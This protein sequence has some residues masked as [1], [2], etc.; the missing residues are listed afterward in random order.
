M[1]SEPLR[2]RPRHQEFFNKLSRWC[3]R[4][5]MVENHYWKPR[6][7]ANIQNQL[8]KWLYGSRE[9]EVM[10]WA[11]LWSGHKWGLGTTWKVKRH[12][13]T[14]TMQ[15]GQSQGGARAWR[16]KHRSLELQNRQRAAALESMTGGYL[17]LSGDRLRM[18]LTS[19][20]RQ[21]ENCPLTASQAQ[22]ME[23]SQGRESQ[24]SE[25]CFSA[26]LKGKPSS[27]GSYPQEQVHRSSNLMV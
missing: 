5:V 21:P 17:E 13:Q 12:V 19:L 16:S 15:W 14:E 22:V 9:R 23:F 6:S 3:Q 7:L 4:A 11:R 25:V 18:L 24:E 8:S 26:A 20:K 10:T 1:R 27:W 2:I